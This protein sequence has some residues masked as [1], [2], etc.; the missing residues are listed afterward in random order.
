MGSPTASGSPKS[1]K[2]QLQE[3]ARGLWSSVLSMDLKAPRTSPSPDTTTNDQQEGQHMS[4]ESVI[5]VMFTSCTTGIDPSAPTPSTNDV[6]FET[7]TTER[8]PRETP[9][10]SSPSRSNGDSIYR[11]L[12]SDSHLRAEEAVHH[13]REQLEQKKMERSPSRP[14]KGRDVPGMF[15]ASSPKN[16]REIEVFKPFSR[17]PVAVAASEST[18]PRYSFSFDDGVSVITQHTLE[19]QAKRLETGEISWVR[20][21]IT[22]D[23]I[24]IAEESWKET[25]YPRAART[26]SPT[27]RHAKSSPLG[28]HKSS[29]RSQATV[30]TKLSNGAKSMATKSTLST[31]TNEFASAWQK[32]ELRYWDE[33]VKEQEEEQFY[34]TTS[35]VVRRH[36]KVMRAREISRKMRQACDHSPED[37]VR[38]F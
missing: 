34:S 37:S 25:M 5:R 16:Q 8:P 28:F 33:V 20:S 12:F 17:P 4:L 26:P 29:N 11:A 36:R 15:P 32:E 22:Q 10:P 23:P 6:K 2:E 30:H 1:V 31:Q 35:E 3:S 27:R 14:N 24:E 18:L 19:E 38:N 9:Q 13:L 21:D 7:S